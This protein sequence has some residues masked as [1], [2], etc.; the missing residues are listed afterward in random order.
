MHPLD[1]TMFVT[2]G[3]PTSNAVAD[4]DLESSLDFCNKSAIHLSHCHN[5]KVSL[6]ECTNVLLSFRCNM[7]SQVRIPLRRKILMDERLLEQQKCKK[8]TV[9]GP[10]LY[11]TLR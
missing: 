11:Q 7:L 8:R 10:I 6:C 1:R 2:R 5:F 9:G 3:S 4:L